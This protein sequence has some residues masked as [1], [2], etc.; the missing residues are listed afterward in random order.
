MDIVITVA[1]S[2]IKF[3]AHRWPQKGAILDYNTPHVDL[4]P[5]DPS[6]TII[7]VDF[8]NLLIEYSRDERPDLR[9]LNVPVEKTLAEKIMFWRKVGYYYKRRPGYD[10]FIRGLSRIPNT[11]LYLYS[12]E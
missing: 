2:F 11:L 9:R 4:E 8:K 1:S 3:V 6:K 5:A 7:T 10:S 12:S